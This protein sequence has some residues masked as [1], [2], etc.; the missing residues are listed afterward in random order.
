MRAWWARLSQKAKALPGQVGERFWKCWV[1]PLEDDLDGQLHVELLTRA[2]A[3][4]TVEVADRIGDHAKT[5]GC[6]RG[7]VVIRGGALVARIVI[8]RIV[9][10]YSDGSYSRRQVDAIEDVEH[11]SAKLDLYP[12]RNGNVL[13]HRE[14]HGSKP[15]PVELVAGDIAIG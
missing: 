10:A 6:R 15:G 11:F 2:K 7:A 8:R 3:G 1:Q 14:I 4:S 12:L 5:I 13:E 9:A